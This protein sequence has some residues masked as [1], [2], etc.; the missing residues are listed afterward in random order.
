MQPA[1]RATR[2]PTFSLWGDANATAISRS[3]D[4][5]A[6][7]TSGNTGN[8][9]AFADGFARSGDTGDS[10]ANAI[11]M[12][13]NTGSA[14]SNPFSGSRA[15]GGDGGFGGNSGDATGSGSCCTRSFGKWNFGGVFGSTGY[16]GDGGFGG[17]AK[18]GS[19]AYG[20]A[21]SGD[22]T[23]KPVAISGDTG[24]SGHATSKPVG[25]GL[26]R[27]LQVRRVRAQ[28]RRGRAVSKTFA[29]GCRKHSDIRERRPEA[30]F[31]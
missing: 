24:D 17:N 6:T 10:N 11:G 5:N 28:R 14:T 30:G 26:Q 25:E 13:G 4:A 3:G 8:A 15:K 12:A 7:S 16:G 1:R 20:K 2:V 18:S 22:S 31:A 19:H 29:W 9:A 21:Y 23:A 27:R